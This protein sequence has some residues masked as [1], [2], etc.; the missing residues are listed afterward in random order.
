MAPATTLPSGG[1]SV[2]PI[3]EWW[4]L[5]CCVSGGSCIEG[6]ACVE[7]LRQSVVEV[8]RGDR[9]DTWRAAPYLKQTADG[10]EDY[11]CEGGYDD[12]GERWEWLVAVLSRR[13]G[14]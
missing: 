10:G 7:A 6:A 3:I 1:S 5:C 8:R 9:E 2:E 14:F 13:P 12:A 11:D 4:P